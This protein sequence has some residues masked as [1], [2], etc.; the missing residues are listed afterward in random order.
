M[1]IHINRSTWT[2]LVLSSLLSVGSLSSSS[3]PLRRTIPQSISGIGI[4]TSRPRT[5]K[6]T[7]HPTATSR[8]RFEGRSSRINP[9]RPMRIT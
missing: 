1:N 9:S 4:P 6:R 5:C 8:S 7:I 3:R 2:L